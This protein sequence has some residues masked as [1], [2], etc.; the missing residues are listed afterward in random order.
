MLMKIKL[1]IENGWKRKDGG[2]ALQTLKFLPRSAD[3]RGGNA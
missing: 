1:V 3:G 2:V